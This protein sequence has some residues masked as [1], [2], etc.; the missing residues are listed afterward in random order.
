[1][2]KLFYLIMFTLILINITN[3]AT[4]HG[5]VYDPSLDLAKDAT[6]EINTEPKQFY[7]AKD[8]SYS[9]NIPPGS[10]VIKAT[11]KDSDYI[12]VQNITI[13]TDGDFIIDLLLF[14]SFEAEEEILNATEMDI[15]EYPKETDYYAYL[16][17]AISII[18]LVATVYIILKKYMTKPKQNLSDELNEIVKVIQKRGRRINQKDLRKELNLSEAKVSLM[19][20]ELEELG[21]IKRF[22]KGR[23]NIIVLNK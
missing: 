6:I 16:I 2:K 21:V 8:G 5:K 1:M 19:L 14:P 4:I 13:K 3:A 11:S 12:A 10:Y 9:F 18:L 22:K 15:E 20:A 23:G 7:I 17:S